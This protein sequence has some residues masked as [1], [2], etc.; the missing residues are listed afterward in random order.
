MKKH[1]RD[2]KVTRN[3]RLSPDYFILELQS[4]GELPEMHPGQFAEVLVEN[5][6]NVFLRRPFSIHDVDYKENTFSILIKIVGNGT[7]QLSYLEEGDYLDVMFPLGR[8]F[9]INGT[10]NYLLVGGGCGVAPLLFLAKRL[11]EKGLPPAILI[12][13][14]TSEDIPEQEKYEEAGR[15]FITTEDGSLG[16]H[17]LVIQHSLLTSSGEKFDR[18]YTCGPEAM[19]KAVGKYATSSGTDCEVSLENLMACGIGACLCCVVQTKEGHKCTCTD[20]PVFNLKE[21]TW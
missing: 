9:S 6:G 7:R 16:E 2:L 3:R 5:T 10:G 1:I 11:N 8:P 12:G 14:K 17:G 13:G 19:M 20:G 4:F 15:L 18:I 21:L